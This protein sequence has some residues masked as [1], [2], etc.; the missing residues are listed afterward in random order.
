MSRPSYPK[1][2]DRLLKPL[3]FERDGYD[4][5]RVRGG[6]WECVNLQISWVAGVTANIEMKD[7]ETEKILQ[8]IPC[9][10]AIFLAPARMRI[11]HLIDRHDRWWKNDPDGPEELTEAVRTFGLPWFDTVRTVED[12]AERW[13]GRGNSSLWRSSDHPL[14]RVSP[15][16]SSIVELA[17]TLY[18][19]GEFAEA[20]ALFEA[21]VPKTAN[22]HFVNQGRCVQR[23]LERQAEA[24][25][26]S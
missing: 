10:P 20:R 1:S 18:R 22:P 3:G 26:L 15:W 14:G 24:S 6:M 8:S 23:W 7:L 12:Q 4:W 16:R 17:V 21:P 5:I 9:D 11:G 13:Y 19:M 25:P 2:L